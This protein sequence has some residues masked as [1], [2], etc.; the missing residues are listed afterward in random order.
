VS[1]G[2]TASMD[3]VPVLRFVQAVVPLLIQGAVL[4][5]GLWG[6]VVF[7][8]RPLPGRGLAL[9]IAV[10][11]GLIVGGLTEVLAAALMG[12]DTG[13]RPEYYVAAL[14]LA[15]EVGVVVALASL[16][17][18]GTVARTR[19][20]PVAIAGSVL[21]P[22]LFFAVAFGASRLGSEAGRL[23]SEIEER[24][25]TQEIAD[26]SGTIELTVS[27]VEPTMT[28]DRSAVS[29]LSLRVILRPTREIALDPSLKYPLPGFSIVPPGS[30]VDAVSAPLPP[31]APT[32]LAAATDAVYDL[33]FDFPRDSAGSRLTLPPGTWRL[34]VAFSDASGAD[35]LLERDV[36]VTAD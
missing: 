2:W 18:Y 24:Q 7:L 8:S 13:S 1:E 11:V 31:G 23:A 30:V 5:F 6:L 25:H 16:A 21:G 14:P 4:L 26:R 9:T 22:V 36:I 3:T 19:L 34:R 33:T 35:Y 29:G 32:V 27:Q 20:A 12:F 10:G 17:G 28:A 15:F